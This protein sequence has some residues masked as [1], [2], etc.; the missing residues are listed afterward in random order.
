MPASASIQ[1]NVS[2]EGL[3]SFSQIDLPEPGA[4]ALLLASGVGLATRRRRLP[5][6]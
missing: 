2:V 3:E 6:S 5:R 1:G 4:A